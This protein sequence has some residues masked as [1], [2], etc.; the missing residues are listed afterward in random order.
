M[1]IFRSTKRFNGYST[2]FRQWRS[3]H[4]HCQY[5]HGYSISF[6]VWFE[7]ELDDKNWVADFGDLDEVKHWLADLLDHTTVVA[8]D[9]PLLETFRA[10]ER[11]GML[12]LRIVPHVGCERFAEL[13]FNYINTYIQ[14][15]TQGRVR[16]VQVECFE[17]GTK[18]SAICCGDI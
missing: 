6:K 2:A 11:Q 9:D 10:L 8:D 12:Q 4:S 18:N 3:T 15:K 16:V 17:D 13:T 1:A 7:G 14:E 5:L